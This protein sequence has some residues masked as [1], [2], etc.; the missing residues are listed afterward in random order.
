MS[1]RNL[2]GSLQENIGILT[3]IPTENEFL[4]ISRGISEEISRK[5]KIWVSSE[6]PRNIP[7]EFL[8]N[9]NPSEYSEEIARKSVFLGKDR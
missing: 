5:P 4:G 2:T 9:I 8:G 1:R 3:D 6:F 7:T